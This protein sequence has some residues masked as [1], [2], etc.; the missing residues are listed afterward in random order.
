MP[1]MRF[2][3]MSFQTSASSAHTCSLYCILTNWGLLSDIV[4]PSLDTT[5]QPIGLFSATDGCPLM[6]KSTQPTM[7]CSRSS[8][9]VNSPR[10]S[11]SST[12]PATSDAEPLL[13]K[14]DDCSVTPPLKSAPVL[15]R[16]PRASMVPLL[17]TCIACSSN[18]LSMSSRNLVT[19]L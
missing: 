8:E 14:G 11:N 10:M 2:E 7:F 9:Y 4:L 6:A 1:A 16:K 3:G 15:R 12:A 13:G 18:V 19:T 17:K 5:L